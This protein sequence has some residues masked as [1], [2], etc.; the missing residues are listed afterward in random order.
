MR[1]N[2]QKRVVLVRDYVTRGIHKNN[3]Q[4]Q[5]YKYVYYNVCM[6]VGMCVHIYG[7]LSLTGHLLEIQHSREETV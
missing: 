3:L 6:Y 4:I 5:T 1:Q 2:E 7:G